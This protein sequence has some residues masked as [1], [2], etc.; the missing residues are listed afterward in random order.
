MEFKKRKEHANRGTQQKKEENEYISVAGHPLFRIKR[1]ESFK[2]KEGS[3]YISFE[4]HPLSIEMPK[5]S[6]K[7][8]ECS[9]VSSSYTSI[10][11]HELGSWTK[12][13]KATGE[14]REENSSY[15]S[16]YGQPLSKQIRPSKKN[17]QCREENSCYMSVQGSVLP[18]WT[19]NNRRNIQ[20]STESRYLSFRGTELPHIRR[21]RLVK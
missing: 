10:H 5:P 9:K 8:I 18:S 1:C 3:N 21:I 4:G 13:S 19:K 16:V 20:T 6:K 2:T 15:M 11:G 14:C 12:F 17:L 7:N